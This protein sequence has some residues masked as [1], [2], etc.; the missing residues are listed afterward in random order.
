MTGKHSIQDP[1]CEQVLAQ[2]SLYLYGELSF[3]EEEGVELHLERCASCQERLDRERELHAAFD[4][5][6]MEPSPSLLWD[7]RHNLSERLREEAPPS[8]HSSWWDRIVSALPAFPMNTHWTRPVGALAL[9]TLGFAG[10]HLFPLGDAANSPTDLMSMGGEPAA[11]RVRFVDPGTDGRVRIVLDETRQRTITG[12]LDDDHI[13][14]LLLSAAK[15]PD[16]PGLRAETLDI[17]NRK[18]Q[19]A[20]VRGA[21]LYALEH[22]ENAGVRL[23]ALEGLRP[24]AGHSEVQ[25]TLARVLLNDSN[26]GVRTQAI[27]LLTAA[28]NQPDFDRE[29]VGTLQE[30]LRHESNDYV[31]LRSERLLE[32]MN[33]SAEIY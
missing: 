11:S 32:T 12:G 9:V 15:D 23:K 28:D 1:G 3:E 25:S 17:L 30:L 8:A 29:I 16:D 33:A 27:D 21:L 5:A 20:D 7:A 26:P 2:L 24:F 6:V 18:A 14:A 31:R 22:D 4:R 19:A 13:R 10:A